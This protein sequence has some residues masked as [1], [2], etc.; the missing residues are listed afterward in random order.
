MF[1]RRKILLALLQKF[2]G[3]LDKMSIQK[4]LFL[5]TQV[6]G[7]NDYDFIP[8]RFGCYSFTANFDLNVMI[9]KGLIKEK[10]NDYEKNDDFDYISQLK[11]ND[12]ISLNKIFSD[13]S[14]LD[15]MSLIKQTYIEYPFYSIRSEI[16]SSLLSKTE[17]DYVES[18]IPKSSDTLLFTIGYQGISLEK[19]FVNLIKNDVKVLVDV[20]NNPLSMKFG[21]NKNQLNKYCTALGI[22]YIHL[23]EVGIKNDYRKS[24]VTEKDYENLFVIYRNEILNLTKKSQELIIELLNENKRIAL[25]CFEKNV[26]FCHRKHLAEALLLMSES[27]FEIKHL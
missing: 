14:H 20:R 12:N 26:N 10:E 16:I 15:K 21:F 22:K 6:S 11:P 24:L 4:L 3:K 23:P 13:Y 2:G 9:S 7:N 1:Y 18:F 27:N 19:Y 25:T 17:Q 8:Y 5:F